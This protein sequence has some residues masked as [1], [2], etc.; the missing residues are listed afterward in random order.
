M[1]K[2]SMRGQGVVGEGEEERNKEMGLTIR[3]W[4]IR[5]GVGEEEEGW[6]K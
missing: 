3:D 2:K 1:V 4:K 5:E 6:A